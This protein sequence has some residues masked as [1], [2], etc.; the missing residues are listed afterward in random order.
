MTTRTYGPETHPDLAELRERYERAN[1]SP[2]TGLA[3]GLLLLAGLFL[4]LSPWV[5][6]P[7]VAFGLAASNMIIG[8]AVALL[9]VGY[10]RSFGHLHVIAWVT[11]IIGAWVIV[12]PWAIYRRSG[13]VPL[14][15]NALAPLGTATWL[16]NVIS[17]GVVVL[18]GIALMSFGRRSEHTKASGVA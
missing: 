1:Q 9:A 11:P 4:T 13:I 7:L 6:Q 16:S 3:S 15:V 12:S 17:G 18:A 14:D 5:I 8:V 10:A 2:G